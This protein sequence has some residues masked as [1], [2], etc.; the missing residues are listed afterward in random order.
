MLERVLIVAAIAL[1]AALLYAL[2]RHWQQRQLQGLQETP[3]TLPPS[4]QG[5]KPAVLYFTTQECAQCRLQQTPILAQL[6]ARLDVAVHKLDAIEQRALADLY[7]IMTVPST[8]V[9]NPELRP[10]AINQGVAPLQKLQRQIV[11][12]SL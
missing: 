9:L 8:V 7:G 3:P 2:W 6:Q 5:G 11:G 10:V 1:A 12:D 4:V